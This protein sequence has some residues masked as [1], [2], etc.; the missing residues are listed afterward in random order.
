MIIYFSIIA[1]H[2]VLI[3]EAFTGDGVIA[4]IVDTGFDFTHPDFNNFI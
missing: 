2:C 1:Q 4:G 3:I